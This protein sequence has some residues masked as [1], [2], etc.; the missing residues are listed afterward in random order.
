MYMRQNERLN[1]F[2]KII[3]GQYV[4]KQLEN[5]EKALKGE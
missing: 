4:L 5:N 2:K 1:S 3:L